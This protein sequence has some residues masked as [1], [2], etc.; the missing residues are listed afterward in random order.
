[1]KRPRLDGGKDLAGKRRVSDSVLAS[2]VD[3]AMD[4]I[5]GIDERQRIIL[6]NGAAEGMFGRTAGQMI[7]QSID[8]LLPKRFRP[9]HAG[10]VESFGRSRTTRRAMGSLGAVYGL[11]AD[12]QEF[13]LEASI[14]Q[15]TVEG[16]RIFA[17][18]LRD[19][20]ERLRIEEA[21]HASSALVT[22]IVE[23]SYDAIIG[24]TLD[25][26]IISWNSGAE[27][28]FG[29]TAAEALGRAITMLFPPERIT[30]EA[31][32]LQR[33]ARGERVERLETERIRKDGRRIEVSITTSPLRD[34]SGRIIG[35]SKIARDVTEQKRAHER[36]LR[37]SR[38]HSVL[39]SINSLIVRSRDRQDLL[40][41]ACS[42]AV[43]QGGFGAAWIGMLDDAD[44]LRTVAFAGPDIARLAGDEDLMTDYVRRGVGLIG[45]AITQKTPAFS[46]DLAADPAQLLT[47]RLRVSLEHG[48]HSLIALP[49]LTRNNAI[50]V[51]QLFAHEKGVIDESELRLLT[52]IAGDISFALEHIEQEEQLHHL[53]YH[54]PLTG[55]PNRLLLFDRLEQALRAARN[56]GRRLALVFG[57]I[58]GFRQVNDTWGR[59]AGDMVLRELA[60]R[61]K[62]LAPEPENIARISGDYYAGI[63]SSFRSATD[64][65]SLIESSQSGLLS[66][67]YHL[68]ATELRITT[69]AGIAIFPQDGTDAETLLRNAEAAHL[70]ARTSGQPYLFYEPE[71]NARVAHTLLLESQLRSAQERRQFLLHYQPIVSAERSSE[72]IGLE[73]L[74]RWQSPADGLV[75]PDSF[76]PILENTGL[77]V[78]VGQWVIRQARAQQMDW[79][80]SGIRPPR[81]AVNI[82]AVQLQQA[83]FAERVLEILP[84]GTASIDFEIT[85]SVLMQSIEDN[86]H[87]LKRLRDAGIS[88]AVDD[89]GV[90]HSSLSYLTRLPINTVK[91][92]RVF[93][94]KMTTDAQSMAVVSAIISL[95]RTLKLKVIAEGI[96]SEEQARFLRLLG[97]DELQGYLFGKPVAPGEVTPLLVSRH[98]PRV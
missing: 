28:L 22:A 29:Y 18:I 27:E 89:F 91:I 64:L 73:A 79:E 12:G 51:L 32:I 69:R 92:D 20:S 46:N 54:D 31:E 62:K 49:L 25:G 95:A 68:G 5:I 44:A 86:I 34:T 75:H 19:I 55:L 41:S 8:V 52:E 40:L 60:R 96:E 63:I 15:C 83:D 26:T 33:I 50:G 11:R 6:F 21:L 37:L 9:A 97:C 1:M 65:A 42:I 4:G 59:Q 76:I 90:G 72:V 85:E 48:F 66:Q 24:K 30:E 94:S 43:E 58:K 2:L 56:N 10:H 93:V 39:S 17:V 84:P 14:S 80:S 98:H 3:S 81:I 77:I 61:L 35:A 74:L 78:P 13:P 82:S 36:V 45:R 57:D 47:P 67:P 87:K 7:G 88:I 70:R 53:A 16:H 23:S 38:I 71:M